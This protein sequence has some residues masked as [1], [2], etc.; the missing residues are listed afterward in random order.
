MDE[1]IFV[2]KNFVLAAFYSFG[3]GVKLSAMKGKDI[4]GKGRV[5]VF[6]QK[7]SK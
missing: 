4:R 5:F 6:T 3:F 7:S 2:F 1:C